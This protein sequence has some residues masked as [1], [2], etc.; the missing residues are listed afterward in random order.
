MKNKFKN[1]NGVVSVF[2]M[3]S[4]LFFLLFIIGAY[5]TISRVIKTQ[6]ETN[7]T[8]LK[9]YSSQTNAQDVYNDMIAKKSEV[10]PIYTYDQLKNI[11]SNKIISVKGKLYNCL[12]NKRYYELK[13]NL[14]VPDT[15]KYKNVYLGEYKYCDLDSLRLSLDGEN[16]TGD[17]HSNNSNVWFNLVNKDGKALEALKIFGGGTSTTSDLSWANNGLRFDGSGDYVLAP[18]VL[19]GGS[20]EETIEVVFSI[21]YVNPKPDNIKSFDNERYMISNYSDNERYIV[22]NSST[23][24]MIDKSGEIKAKLAG[25]KIDYGELKTNSYIKYFNS[26]IYLAITYNGKNSYLYINGN[27][28]SSIED[29][30]S[31]NT[32]S[33][34]TLN[35]ETKSVRDNQNSIQLGLETYIG[36]PTNKNLKSGITIKPYAVKGDNNLELV[37]NWRYLIEGKDFLIQNQNTAKEDNYKSFYEVTDI[38]NNITSN[39]EINYYKDFSNLKDKTKIRFKFFLGYLF[40]KGNQTPERYNECITFGY[41]NDIKLDNT[42]T[43]SDIAV[44]VKGSN[45]MILKSNVGSISN[46]YNKPDK[47]KDINDQVDADNNPLDY[48]EFMIPKETVEN[49]NQE[50][51]V[52]EEVPKYGTYYYVFK[53]LKPNTEYNFCGKY[54]NNSPD[55]LKN[56][57]NDLYIGVDPNENSNTSFNGEIYAVRVYDK[58][59]SDEEIKTNYN[60]DKERFSIYNDY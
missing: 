14:N 1:Q 13:A 20:A 42:D 30:V 46:W 17:G 29:F 15:E 41:S 25:N 26:P 24:L 9:L 57:V 60:I 49:V 45:S 4:M 28:K 23:K 8:L 52:Y 18:S 35:Y 43:T 34:K 48:S 55:T 12:K 47:N 7:K 27:R 59:L 44:V 19:N 54:N 40:N 11:D 16:N 51:E 5:M 32:V 37:D 53:N 36:T 31:T 6:K 2:A 39:Y 56:D 22:S 21:P 38:S 33:E 58:A 3:L 50:I 10:I